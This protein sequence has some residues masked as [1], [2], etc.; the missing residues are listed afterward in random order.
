MG[1]GWCRAFR[2]FPLLYSDGKSLEF[3]PEVGNDLTYSLK[4]SICYSVDTKISGEET[5]KQKEQ[6][7][8]PKWLDFRYIYLKTESISYANMIP[9]MGWKGVRDS[10]KV[11]SLC[12]NNRA[13]ICWEIFSMHVSFNQIYFC[14]YVFKCYADVDTIHICILCPT[15]KSMIR[16]L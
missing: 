15:T 1:V 10:F 14:K 7:L 16:L 4:G 9:G 3:Q 8:R 11:S 5:E 12:H 13:P 2:V 6:L